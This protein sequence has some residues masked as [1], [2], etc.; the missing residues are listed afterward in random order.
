MKP[1]LFGKTET[2]FTSNGLGRL[3]CVSC[4]ITEERNG[5][6]E[7]ECE[8]TEAAL[9]ASQIEMN[10]FIV[11]K[12]PDQS[13]LQRFRV[14]SI[15]KNI[16]G[17][18]KVSAQHISYQLS[19]IT[20]MPFSVALAQNACATTLAGLKSNA[21][22][23]CPFSF[24]TDV[25]TAS[26]YKQLLP[27]SI[28]SRLGGVEG[29][30]LDQ[31]HGE[32]KWDNYDVYLL[33]NRG[34]TTPTVT[35]RYGKNIIDLQQEE[36]I[37]N[38]ITGIVPYWTDSEGGDL[39][40]LTEKVVE[41]ST[42]SSYPYKRTIP[43]DFSSNFDTKPTELQLRTA[44][45]AYVNSNQVGVPKVSIKLSFVNLADTEEYK[46]IY[47]LQSVNLCDN[48]TVQFEKLGINTTA[49]I[50]KVVY[51]VL[52]ERYNSIEIGDLRS[53]LYSTIS[54]NMEDIEG[55]TSVTKDMIKNNNTGIQGDITQ[56]ISDAETYADGVGTATLGDAKTYADGVGTSTL[57]S[58][59]T[60]ADGVGSSTLG[61]AKTYA[62]GV[63]SSTLG[64]AKTYADGVGSST[65]GSA[66][67][68][69]DGVEQ[70][71]NGY[72]DTKI[73][74]LNYVTPNEL[75]TAVNNATAWLTGADGYVVAVKD[76]NGTWKE[77]LF[78]DHQDPTQWVNVLRL[79]ENGMGFSSDGGAHYTQAW[80]L[81]GRLVIGGTAV[82][83]L[84]VYD[85][86]NNV[87][88]QISASGMQ[89]LSTNS[90][91]SLNGILSATA[92]I[93]NDVTIVGGSIT[94]KN[95]NNQT[96]FSASSA[97]ITWNLANSSMT[98]DGTLT[99]N[100]GRFT[101]Y[102]GSGSSQ[103]STIIEAGRLINYI[104]S[105]ASDSNQKSE[106]QTKSKTV[107]I[108]PEYD[109]GVPG[110][111][112][113]DAE[114]ITASPL[115]LSSKDVIEIIMGQVGDTYDASSNTTPTSITMYDPNLN[116]TKAG[117]I[118]LNGDDIF[119]NSRG[120]L[121]IAASGIAI[122]GSPQDGQYM[123]PG[124]TKTQSLGS[125]HSITVKNGIVTALS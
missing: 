124:I 21:V 64:S 71:A 12:V 121:N 125:G 40:T 59:K 29:S 98:S 9:H 49:E 11:A 117:A 118:V 107:V 83:S 18:Y 54:G 47:P 103:V 34:V 56:A 20:A 45:Q 115:H 37:A 65:L 30:V 50:V 39:V 14:Y 101:A 17:L 62:D 93:L 58:A 95:S 27:A 55:I 1:I 102:R 74:Q 25:T 85:S 3:D 63:G 91:M 73:S 5:I 19:F 57:G 32:F 79:N 120:I 78:A 109:P 75:S 26:S 42:A 72:T 106:I 116:I 69:A 44:A 31:F 104:G 48:I 81:D 13:S 4:L 97:G 61:S 67:T 66:K 8:I 108:T 76:S 70:A 33:K 41:I 53:T 46:D 100:N 35:L 28:K 23:D 22:G 92:A 112:I 77:L 24:H 122:G 111:P 51:D 119:I 6:F 114:T 2:A 123:A 52:A 36:N 99:V 84:T 88:F 96:I 7:L 15:V 113:V 10:S 38:T 94:L 80:T 110:E 87:I 105:I 43:Y 60:Y 89:W 82:P 68:Y 16:N 86:N 90:S